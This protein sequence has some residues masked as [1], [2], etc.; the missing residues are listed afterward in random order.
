MN[1]KYGYCFNLDN[2]DKEELE[3]LLYFSAKNTVDFFFHPRNMKY[4]KDVLKLLKYK[5][6]YEKEHEHETELIYKKGEKEIYFY[7]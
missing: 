2:K 6:N 1:T 7:F 4:I 5:K 3:H